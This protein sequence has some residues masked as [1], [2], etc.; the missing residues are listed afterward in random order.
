LTITIE[1]R[2]EQEEEEAGGRRRQE[3]LE[4]QL[5]N[6]KE[7]WSKERER[8]DCPTTGDPTKTTRE[9]EEH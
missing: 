8:V 9:R 1:I 6:K 3:V 7:K 4:R 5:S 2:K